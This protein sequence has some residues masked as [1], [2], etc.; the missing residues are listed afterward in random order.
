MET[1]DSPPEDVE[2]VEMAA[3][4]LSDDPAWPDVASRAVDACECLRPRPTPRPTPAPMRAIETMI[5]AQ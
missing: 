2:T 3:M 5:I 1:M 4:L